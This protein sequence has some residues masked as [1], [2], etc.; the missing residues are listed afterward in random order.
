MMTV[1]RSRSILR[2]LRG[3]IALMAVVIVATGCGPIQSTQR[4]SEAE[5]AF[6]RARVA[7]AMV[8]APYEYWSAHHY[9]YKAKEEWGYSDFEAAYDYATQARRAAEAAL[10]KSREDPW[11]GHPVLSAEE[12]R[13]IV[14]GE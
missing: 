6:E 9:L 10:L 14:A 1:E 8:R 4:I 3:L 7:E 2:L 12:F 11:Q 13:K 5:V